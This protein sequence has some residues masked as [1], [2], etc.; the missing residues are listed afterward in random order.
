M[1][2]YWIVQSPFDCAEESLRVRRLGG[3]GPGG[4]CNVKGDG[5]A[6]VG[7]IGS[8]VVEP[9][10]MVTVD[11]KRA[12]EWLPMLRFVAPLRVL[13]DCWLPPNIL[14]LLVRERSS[15]RLAKKPP[16]LRRWLPCSSRPLTGVEGP[17][18][19]VEVFE[20]RFH[21]KILL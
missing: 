5:S 17:I 14:S 4:T 9:L 12:R 16:A 18:S 8:A 3:T 19:G 10:G 21:G 1:E 15:L 13:V 2:D 11:S 20:W 7:G 6:G